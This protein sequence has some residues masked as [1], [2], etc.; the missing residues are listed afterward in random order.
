MARIV[1]CGYMIR[2]PVAGNLLA[3]FHYVLGLARLGHEVAYL[4]ESGGWADSCYDPATRKSSEDP[5][6]G[7]KAVHDLLAAFGLEVP[8]WYVHRESRRTAGGTWA[9]VAEAI[10]AA[11][12]LLNVGG[13]CWL[14]EFRTFRRRALVDMDPLFTQA[15]SFGGGVVQEHDVHFTYGGNVGRPGCRVP[16]CGLEW[17][18]TVPPV[19]REPWDAR[20]APPDAPFTTVASWDAY[21]SVRVDGVSYGQK[22][23]EFRRFLHLPRHSRLPLEVALAGGEAVRAR[24]REAGWTVRDS[25]EVSCDVTAYRN[26]IGGSRAEFSVAKNAYVKSRSGWFSDRTVCYLAAGRPAVVQDTG[27]GDWLPAVGRGVL[28]FRTPDEAVEALERVARDYADH[29]AAASEL[30]A[31]TFDYRVVLPKLLATALAVG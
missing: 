5:V 6:A 14:E 30:A 17:H 26:Y 24:L 10:R 21:G 2:H 8:V 18:H 19:V 29:S 12:L 20:P 1:V 4:E 31:G 23:R 13:I 3:F 16:T 22:G 25:G 28:S 15:G 11:D 27:F 7:L 9:D